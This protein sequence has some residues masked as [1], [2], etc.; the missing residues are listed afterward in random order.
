MLMLFPTNA[1][2][3]PSDPVVAVGEIRETVQRKSVGQ[4]DRLY[5][6]GESSYQP[7]I[8]VFFFCGWDGWEGLGGVTEKDFLLSTYVAGHL[9]LVL[10]QG[11]ERVR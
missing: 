5:G 4:N 3:G 2:L 9:S 8:W 11:S 6:S 10:R 7:R 1:P